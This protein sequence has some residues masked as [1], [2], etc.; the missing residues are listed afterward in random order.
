MSDPHGSTVQYRYQEDGGSLYPSAIYYTTP[1]RCGGG[2]AASARACAV[3]LSEYAHRVSFVYEGRSDVTSSYVTTWRT[4]RNLRLKRIELTSAVSDIGTRA[5]VRRY[6]LRYEPTSYHS[7]LAS[8]QLE[9]RPS[10]RE[11]TFGVVVGEP[12]VPE[13]SLGDAIIGDVFPPMTFIYSRPNATSGQVTGFGGIDSTVHRSS[14]SPDHSVDEG[15]VD[16]FD[17]NADGLPDLLVTD[18]AKY[19]G[20]AGVYFNG[21]AGNTPGTPAAFSVGTAVSIPS[22]LG[23]VLNLSSANIVPMDVDGDGRGDILHMPRTANYGYFV[24]SKQPTPRGAAYQPLDGWSFVHVSDLLPAGVTDPRIDLGADGVSIRTLDVNN[25]HLI[26]VV[27][28]TGSQ[29]QTWLNLG[30]YPGGEGRFGSASSA[31]SAWNLS[32][33]PVESCLPYAGQAID[34]GESNLRIADMN[35]DGLADIVKIAKDDVVWWPGRGEGAFGDGSHACNDQNRSKRHIRM[36]NPPQ[37]L[38]P[39]L[40]GMQMVDVNGDGTTDLLLVGKDF[41][42]IWFNEGGTAFSE[43]LIVDS[44]P[45]AVDVLDRVRVADI[46]GSTTADVIYAEGGHYRWI[47]LMGGVRPRLLTGVDNG[48][49]AFTSLQYASSAEDYLRDLASARSCDASLADCFTWHREPLMPG[50]NEAGCDAQI[51]SHSDVCAHRVAG[52][53]VLSSVV[54]RVSTTDRFDAMGVEATV[55]ETEYRYHDGYYEGIEQ[56]FRGFGAADAI[57]VGDQY[58]PTSI[59]RSYFHQGR[60]PNEIAADRLADNPNEALKG[61]EYLNESSD[62]NGNYLSTRHATYTVRRIMTGLNGTSISYAYVS[63]SEEF[64]Y[65]TTSRAGSATTVEMQSVLREEAREGRGVNAVY[66]AAAQAGDAP[67]VVIARQL[68]FARLRSTTDVVDNVGNEVQ[69]TAWGRNGTGEYGETVGDERITSVTLPTRI[70]D[71]TCS[72]S[73]WMWRGAESY[74]AD[75]GGQYD[76]TQNDFSTCGDL[77][78]SGKIASLPAAGAFEFA[79]GGGAQG[80]THASDMEVSSWTLDPW[81]QVVDHCRGGIVGDQVNN[82]CLRLSRFTHDPVYADYATAEAIAVS[83]TGGNLRFLVSTGVWDRGLG[84]LRAVT[85]A[86][87]HVSETSFDGLGRL[88]SQI[89][90][91]VKGCE[92]TRVPTIR[93]DYALTSAPATTPLNRA[94]TTTFLS[95]GSYSDPDSQVV[96]HSYVD[97]LGRIRATLAEGESD[98]QAWEDNRGHAFVLSGRQILTKQGNPRLLYQPAYFD[99]SPDDYAAVI[100]RPASPYKRALFDAFGRATLSINE[101]NTYTSISYHALSRDLCDEVDNGF[102]ADGNQAFNG[103]CTTERTDGHGRVIDQQRRQV[104]ASGAREHHRLFTYY[105]GDGAVVRVV[106]ALTGDNVL[107]YEGAALGAFVERRFHYDSIGRRIASEDPD[108]DNRDETTLTRRT[109]RYLFNRAGDLIAVRDPRGCGQN[110]YYDLA[111]RLLGEAYVSC[112]EAQVGESPSADIPTGSVS[113][114]R[115]SGITRVHTRYYFDDYPLWAHDPLPGDEQDT[116][117]RPTAHEDRAQR[118]AIAYNQRGHAVWSGKQLAVIAPAATLPGSPTVDATSGLPRF[119]G[120]DETSPGPSTVL[121]DTANTYARTTVIDHAGRVVELTL[122]GGDTFGDPDLPTVGGRLEYYRNGAPRRAEVLLQGV[123]YPV[124][125]RATYTRDGLLAATEY[126]DRAFT[127]RVATQTHVVYDARR[128]PFHVYTSRGRTPSAPAQ[129]LGYVSV[130]TDQRYTWDGT[131][132]LVSSEDLRPTAEWPDGHKPVTQHVAHDALYRVAQVSHVY[133]TNDGHDDATDWRD[134]EEAH[135]DADPMAATAAPMLPANPQDRVVDL[136]YNHDWLANM[137]S[138]HDD[139]HAFYE[140]SLGNITN[141]NAVSSGASP[142]R[143][144]AALYL[145]SNLDA[146]TPADLGGWLEADYGRGGNLLA[147]TAHA[148]CTHASA[149]SCADPGGSDLS[150]RRSALRTGC[151]CQSEQHYVYRWDAI[152]RLQEARRYDRVHQGAWNYAAR[153][154]YR[155]DAAN[156]RTINKPSRSARAR[157]GPRCTSIQATSSDEE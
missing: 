141:G 67:H 139:G 73:G 131:G 101:D 96:S 125:A 51:A 69:R 26:D 27:R 91:A 108:T 155:Y 46:D 117:G 89:L 79:G 102:T 113:L 17:V 47:D 12:A 1:A 5:L 132:N 61:R 95:C 34:F 134:A 33:S 54:R 104:T 92:G 70:A 156:E 62:Q 71:A 48:L 145:A 74:V 121:Y 55:S 100:A 11:G 32:T 142:A 80:F 153:Q 4:E 140:R 44:T 109:W 150:V 42:S 14:S 39:D 135:R 127:G 45:F 21:F 75:A 3:E 23:S 137:T 43:R 154:R 98:S 31:G 58:E 122:P 18:P 147:M 50:A 60:R 152:N 99:G 59:T 133:P 13:T 112:S 114:G 66:A 136:E 116:L 20:G 123:A 10:A 77:Q 90:P 36:G 76:R 146:T 130:I 9:G 82:P 87:G 138:W 68:R 24:L 6:H 151:S 22:G 110:F 88:T 124:I 49:G 107:R 56:E 15:R 97:G 57:A 40:A 72:N 81:G 115:T 30:R 64:R 94:T 93:V 105:R 25:D 29:L 8:V 16:F 157:N 19:G 120:V 118:T 41:L 63:G 144:P 143:R 128:R 53:P 148:Q 103:T 111:G 78:M 28:T 65:D 83:G 126:G 38:N 7:L 119:D 84:Q 35:G 85:D 2:E 129:T 149:T 86:N 37:E 52:S 106:R